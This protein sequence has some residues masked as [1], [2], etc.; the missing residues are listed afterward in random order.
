[1]NAEDQ[2]LLRSLLVDQRLAAVGLVVEGE[3][4]VGLLPFT[5]SEDF[6]A[7]V[8]QASALARHSRGLLQGAPFSAVI[9]RPDAPDADALQT[10]RVLLE[11]EVETLEQDEAGR[12]AATRAYLARFRSAAMTLSLPDFSVYRLRMRAGRLVVGFGR[13]LNLDS[14]HFR[15]LAKGPRAV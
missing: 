8:V 2:A 4:V 1:M 10:P 13:A 6:S 12:E 9:H 3:P 15:D 14:S 7:L 5:V 11:G